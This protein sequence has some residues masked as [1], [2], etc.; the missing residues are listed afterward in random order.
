[1]PAII[2]VAYPRPSGEVKFDLKYYIETHMPL[3]DK[4]WGPKGLKSWTVT[5]RKPLPS[6]R[7]YCRQ[8]RV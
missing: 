4:T 7:L 1:M 5:E 3:V 6:L 8:L 2:T